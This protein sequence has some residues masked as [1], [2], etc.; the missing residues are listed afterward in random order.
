[1]LSNSL[2]QL[3]RWPNFYT[4]IKRERQERMSAHMVVIQQSRL[5]L[6]YGELYGLVV[7]AFGKGFQDL[8]E[9][10]QKLTESML[11][12]FVRKEKDPMKN[13]V[14]LWDNYAGV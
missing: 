11:W 9:L 5:V 7:G 12:V 8:H 1:M 4:T 2:K 13:L 10:V 3:I 6:Q 14:S